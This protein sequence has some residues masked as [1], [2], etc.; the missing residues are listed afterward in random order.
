MAEYDVS[1]DTAI[2][3]GGFTLTPTATADDVT[4]GLSVLPSVNAPMLTYRGVA[5][6]QQGNS[7]TLSFPNN[8]GAVA[9]LVCVAEATSTSVHCDVS[10]SQ[11]FK[12]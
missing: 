11:D 7:W 3:A 1:V 10:R 4:D 9:E 5:D 6:E 12:S 2:A 8:A